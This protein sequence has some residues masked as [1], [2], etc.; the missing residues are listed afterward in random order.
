MEKNFHIPRDL[1]KELTPDIGGCLA[2]DRII[3]DGRFVGY[4]YREEPIEDIDSG[5]RFMA[6]DESED[7]MENQDNHG[8]YEVNTLANY[9][10]KIISLLDQPIG[11]AFGRDNIEDEFS[12][13]IE[14]VEQER[15]ED[16]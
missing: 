16:E 6:G 5:W 12:E 14:D 9:D 10:Q 13:V 4:M 1:M 11:S 3:E 8:F 2:T 7:Y 15:L